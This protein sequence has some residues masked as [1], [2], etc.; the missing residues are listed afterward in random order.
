[1]IEDY[2]F[3]RP[4]FLRF[5]N[6]K[7]YGE[8]YRVLVDLEYKLKTNMDTPER[9]IKAITAVGQPLAQLYRHILFWYKPEFEVP[10]GAQYIK[11]KSYDV[12]KEVNNI[13]FAVPE[14]DIEMAVL[15]TSKSEAQLLEEHNQRKKTAQLK[16][17]NLER[18][19]IEIIVK[20]AD[21]FDIAA[22][23]KARYISPSA[24]VDGPLI[25]RYRPPGCSKSWRWPIFR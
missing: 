22:N 13:A 11:L 4:A 5:L 1:V 14:L 20:R 18:K 23:T 25:N 8:F 10:I 9:L 15:E 24:I 6:P 17:L 12:Q 2:T 7:D 3:R 16:A 21:V 19:L